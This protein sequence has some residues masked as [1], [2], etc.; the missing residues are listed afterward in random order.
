MRPLVSFIA[1]FFALTVSAGEDLRVGLPKD[2]KETYTEYLSLD[3]IQ[4]HDQ[5]IR[6]FANDVAMKGADENG[7]L[8]SGSVIVAEIYSVKKNEDG[9][10]AKSL[11]NRRVKD[12]LLLLGVMEKQD[13]FA[14]TSPS[15]INVGDW[16]FAAFKPNGDVAPKD[17]DTCRACHAPLTQTDFLFTTQHLP[18][19]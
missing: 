17:L 2:Y 18:K 6:L 1:L 5:F 11:V 12:K 3:R 7:E 10:V 14:E 13:G 19:R 8:L 15:K 9:S 4:N 16:D